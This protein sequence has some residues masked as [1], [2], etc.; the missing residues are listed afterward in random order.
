M[1]GNSEKN[2]TFPILI[3]TQTMTSTQF[4]RVLSVIRVTLMWY[5]C[6]I[7]TVAF[8]TTVNNNMT[9]H[10]RAQEL[11]FSLCLMKA[12]C[13]LLSQSVV[14]SSSYLSLKPNILSREAGRWKLQTDK[15]CDNTSSG[16]NKTLSL[17]LH[18]HMCSQIIRYS[19]VQFVSLLTLVKF[20]FASFHLNV[21]LQP[22]EVWAM[23]IIHAACV[24]R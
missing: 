1:T 12:T 16:H 6:R 23:L 22:V 24:Q 3:T 4:T 8:N 18:T 10:H 19:M 17:S 2:L 7:S 13:S 14:W 9:S 11:R 5:E 21:A 15:S 20:Y